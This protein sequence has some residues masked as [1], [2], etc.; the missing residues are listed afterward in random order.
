MDKHDRLNDECW[1]KEVLPS[2]HQHMAMLKGAGQKPPKSVAAHT[3]ALIYSPHLVHQ[4]ATVFRAVV[5]PSMQNTSEGEHDEA[6]YLGHSS[7]SHAPTYPVPLPDHQSAPA[8]FHSHPPI[9]DQI[10]AS[11]RR[12][13]EHAGRTTSYNNRTYFVPESYHFR[14]D[15]GHANVFL[16]LNSSLLRRPFGARKSGSAQRAYFVLPEPSISTPR[17]SFWA[18]PRRGR[19]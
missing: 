4:P 11:K 5:A 12:R 18:Q 14:T 15:Y 19:G 16:R 17:S 9:G 7:A 6:H 3:V 8:Y 13:N 2:I 1:L 10:R